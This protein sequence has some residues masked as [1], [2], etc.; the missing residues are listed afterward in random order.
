MCVWVVGAG[1][2]VC[3]RK[4]DEAETIWRSKLDVGLHGRTLRAQA[5][6]REAEEDAAQKALLLLRRREMMARYRADAENQAAALA[7]RGLAIY[8]GVDGLE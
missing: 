7:E 8:H 1:V 3:R 6:Q 2:R 5:A 4:K